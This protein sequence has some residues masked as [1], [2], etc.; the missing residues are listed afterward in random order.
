MNR[1]FEFEET[2]REEET[3]EFLVRIPEDLKYF[4]GHFDGNP[5]VPGV[6]QMLPLAW[7]GVA[8]AWPELGPAKE[9]RRLKFREALRPGDEVRLTVSR[10]PGKVRFQIHRGEAV[11]TLGTFVV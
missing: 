5:I 7:E 1:E 2:S 9:L 11:C 10:V 6:A 3:C 8:R 4:D